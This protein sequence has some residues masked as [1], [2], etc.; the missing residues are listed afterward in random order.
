VIPLAHYL[1]QEYG[2]EPGSLA[3]QNVRDAIADVERGDPDALVRTDPIA[4]SAGDIVTALRLEDYVK[5]R[6]RVTR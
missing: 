1:R 4:L 5:P 3:F 2:I 6:Q